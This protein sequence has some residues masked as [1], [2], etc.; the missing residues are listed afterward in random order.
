MAYPV[1]I[2][3]TQ[4]GST[5]G[6]CLCTW[7]AALYFALPNEVHYLDPMIHPL[8]WNMEAHTGHHRSA[9]LVA[10]GK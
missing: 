7:R 2:N 4:I 6:R 10:P 5:S 3:G 8:S 9:V 1:H